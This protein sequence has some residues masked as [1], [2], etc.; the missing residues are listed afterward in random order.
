MNRHPE[1]RIHKLVRIAII[2]VAASLLTFAMMLYKCEPPD[3]QVVQPSKVAAKEKRIDQAST[4]TEM[5]PSAKYEFPKRIFEVLKSKARPILIVGRAGTG[6]TTLIREILRDKAIKQIVVAPTGVAALN[7]GGATIHS[8]FRIPPG[9]SDPSK[10]DRIAGKQATLIRKLE[11]VIIDEISMVR[12]DLLDMIDHR[13]RT[14]RKSEEPFGG[15]QVVMV[16]DFFQLPPVLTDNE[17]ELFAQEYKT[18]YVFSA[19]VFQNLKP[20]IVE[21]SR[22][23]RQENK[24]FTELLANIRNGTN[25]ESTIAKLNSTCF[26]EHRSGK[27]PLL[28]TGHNEIADKYNQAELQKLPGKVHTYGGTLEGD[29]NISKSNLP[30]PHLLYL[31]VGARVMML[32][33][34][35]RQRWANGNLATVTR[36]NDEEIRVRIDGRDSEYLV[37]QE[38][39]ERYA[40][41]LSSGEI[42]SQVVGRYSQFPIKLSWASTIHKA[43]GLTLDDVRIDL[44]YRSFESGQMYVALSR[45][46]SIAGLSFTAPL[47]HKDVITD[48]ELPNL[49]SVDE[50]IS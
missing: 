4:V 49:F 21:L 19:K 34:D 32:K 43:Q 47:S 42:S 29:F 2:A 5:Q 6:K 38:T 22:V 46:T 23:Y 17:A 11:R 45:V 16:G 12:A 28:L 27:V 30:A 50:A 40:Y 25:L 39:W 8:F 36:L 20:Y 10:L 18:R 1:D 9:L 41:A 44:S 14:V 37:E 3:N 15:V 7:C 26:G 48:P 31:K 13:L 35:P 33:N 24:D